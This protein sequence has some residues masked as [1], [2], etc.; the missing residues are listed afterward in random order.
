MVTIVWGTHA[1]PLYWALLNHEG[2]SSLLT[3]KRLLKIA[4]KVLNPYPVLVI[5]D[6]E[7]HS[8]KLA[9]WLDERGVAFALRQKK[10]LHFQGADDEAY[11]ILNHQGFKPGMAKFYI[12][13]KCNKG[14]GLGPF[15]IAVYWKRKYRNKGPKEPWYILTNLPSLKQALTVYR[16]RWG[17][18]QFFKDCK[19]GGY[20]LEA[21]RVNDTRFLA[22]VMVIVIA[23]SLATVAGQHMKEL[24]VEEYAG[25]LQ[26][27][28]DKNPRHSDFGYALYGQ[29]WIYG[30]NIWHEQ[31]VSLMALKPH[32]RLYFQ[33][34]LFALSLMQKAA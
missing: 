22:L 21:T 27:H 13:V 17:I 10:D 4:L 15:N 30:M 7:F 23:Y 11:Q 31:A 28:H 19:T 9:Q 3:Q 8:P 16:C 12:G 24:Q 25:R 2:N 33:R 1:L 14:N 32:K 5:G 6:R 29:R 20:N 26:S 18:E 34:G